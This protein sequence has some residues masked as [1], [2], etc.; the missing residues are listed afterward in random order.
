MAAYVRPGHSP[1]DR[2]LESVEKCWSRVGFVR[3]FCNGN[4]AAAAGMGVT[5]KL[6]DSA[7][8]GMTAPFIIGRNTVVTA[9]SKLPVLREICDK[10]AIR[11]IKKRLKSYGTPEF[12]TDHK[13]YPTEVAVAAAAG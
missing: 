8:V 10:Y 1:V 2:A 11:V 13:T 12:T 6:R 3:A 4:K 9:A 7:V 5:L